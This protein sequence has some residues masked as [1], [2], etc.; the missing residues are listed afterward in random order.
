MRKYRVLHILDELNTGGAERIVFS[1]FQHID[2]EKFQWDFVMTKYADP[3]K[4][5][6]LEDAIESMGGKIYRVHRKRENYLKNIIDID[7]I[8]KKGHYDIV[9][10]HLD[11]LSTF[12]LMSA[13]K[14]KVT[15]RICHSHLAGTDRGR[16]VEILCKLLRPMMF[17]VTTDKFA[18]GND[19]GIALWGKEAVKNGE[20]H[21]MKNAIN[22]EA[23][24]YNEEIRTAKRK[25]LNIGPTSTVIGSVG[26][27]SYQKNSDFIVDIFAK[28]HE[29]NSKS[30]LILVGVGD[31]LDKI[32]EKINQYNLYDCVQLLG[33]RNDVNEIMM[34]MDFFLLPSR[35]EGLPIVMVEAQ[36]VGLPC[37]VSDTITKEI[38]LSK[39]AQYISLNKTADE[40][41]DILDKTSH[42]SKRVSGKEIV[43]N[44]GYEIDSAS[45]DLEEYYT[46]ILRS[47]A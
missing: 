18:C 4:K 17:R 11:E 27:L 26:R 20:V 6:I 25:E 2:R 1:Y 13:K 5:G 31:L 16:G 37:L 33:S 7:T 43:K 19:A 41:A 29:R 47:K 15:V 34:A 35:F 12:Y 40:W 39:G 9:H 10:S 14:Y 44:K 38:A 46:K 23:F 36:C 8:I 45:K 3:E 30:V 32:N 28:F 21:I 24:T 42:D 22:T